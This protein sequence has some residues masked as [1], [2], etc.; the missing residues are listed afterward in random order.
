VL[1]DVRAVLLKPWVPRV[2]ATAMFLLL[3]WEIFTIGKTLWGST[4]E[5]QI[6]EPVVPNISKNEVGKELKSPIFGEFVPKT[7]NANNVKKSLLDLTIVGII[8]SD[9]EERS[10]VI[11]RTAAGEEKPVGIGESI[12]DGVVLKGITTEGIMVDN[13][14]ELESLSFPKNELIFEKQPQPLIKE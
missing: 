5:Q 4:T 7:I 6:P 2:I 9:K 13:Q 8:Y 3:A 10:E 12:A 11:V 14:G 1:N